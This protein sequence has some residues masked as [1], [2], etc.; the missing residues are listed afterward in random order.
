MSTLPERT[1]AMM[2]VDIVS[3]GSFVSFD[4]LLLFSNTRKYFTACYVMCLNKELLHSEN[5][6][7]VFT[8]LRLTVYDNEAVHGSGHGAK[9]GPCN[10]KCVDSLLAN[11]EK[12]SITYD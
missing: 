10:I 12:P 2:F 7:V 4:L 11:D 1:E 3:V 8:L 5:R 6:Q 9:Y